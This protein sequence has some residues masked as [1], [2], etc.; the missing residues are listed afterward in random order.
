MLIFSI[1]VDD[2]S[3][4]NFYLIIYFHRKKM[5]SIIKAAD[6]SLEKNVIKVL[7]NILYCLCGC[8][9]KSG[10]IY[11]YTGL[12]KTSQNPNLFIHCYFFYN[13]G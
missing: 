6:N 7:C 5:F 13:S 9:G 11:I 4:D 10:N 3:F 8:H 2:A 1:T 12:K